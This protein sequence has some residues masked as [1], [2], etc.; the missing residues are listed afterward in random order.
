[1]EDKP[2]N[3]PQ[4][5]VYSTLC[6]LGDVHLV[7]VLHGISYGLRASRPSAQSG[8][9]LEGTGKWVSVKKREECHGFRCITPN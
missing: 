2:E 9:S 1:M 3:R 5:R 4:T 8:C 6:Y 7:S